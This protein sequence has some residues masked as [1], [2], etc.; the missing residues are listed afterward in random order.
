MLGPIPNSLGAGAYNRNFFPHGLVTFQPRF[1]VQVRQEICIDGRVDSVLI[2]SARLN[3]AQL[4]EAGFVDTIP[5]AGEVVTIK[6]LD[7]LVVTI[8]TLDAGIEECS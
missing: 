1:I 4:L 5:L 2:M 3:A 6:T 8:K 7:G